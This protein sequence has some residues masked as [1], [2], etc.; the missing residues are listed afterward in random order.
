MKADAVDAVDDVADDDAYPNGKKRNNETGSDVPG[1]NRRTR[2]PNEMEHWRNVFERPHPICPRATMLF[3]RTV[4]PRI[5][6][7][8]GHFELSS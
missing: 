1:D 2:F 5:S 3:R 4:R 8:A 6:F 7:A